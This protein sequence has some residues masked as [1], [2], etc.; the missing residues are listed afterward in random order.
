[1][2]PRLLV[3][4]HRTEYGIA[5]SVLVGRHV[6][7]RR[8]IPFG[9]HYDARAHE[10]AARDQDRMADEYFRRL[11]DAR[12]IEVIDSPALRAEVGYELSK[13]GKP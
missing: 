5:Y 10:S 11:P 12:Y 1:M 13:R 2:T 6:L 4:I 9:G 8:T 7:W 3:R